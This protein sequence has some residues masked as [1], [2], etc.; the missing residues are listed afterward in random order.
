MWIV[1]A[2]VLVVFLSS[3]MVVVQVEGVSED[4]T[5]WKKCTKKES[6]SEGDNDGEPASSACS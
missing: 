4:V 1:I 5:I 6:G 2:Q 3:D